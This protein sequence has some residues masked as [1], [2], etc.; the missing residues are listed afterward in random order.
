[1]NKDKIVRAYSRL[2]ALKQNLPS[3]YDIHEKYVR[4]YHE[5]IDILSEELDISLDEYKIPNNE[6]KPHKTLWPDIPYV[7][8]GGVAY[9]SDEYCERALLLTK[10]DALLSYLQMEYLFK[11]KPDIGFK[12]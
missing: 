3:S 11:E 12:S 5:I 4:D 2:I 8:K 1:M 9:S 7:Q 6:I 10:L